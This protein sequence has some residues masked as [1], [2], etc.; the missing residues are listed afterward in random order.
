M[1]VDLSLGF[2]FCSIDLLQHHSSKASI[3]WHSAIFTVQLSHPYMTTG[4]TTALTRRTFVGKAMS[5]LFNMLSRLV[6]SFLPRSKH[7][8]IS[9]LQSQLQW[10]WSPRK[11]VSHCSHCFHIYLPWSDGTG[12]HDLRF[13]WMLNFKPAFYSPLSLSRGSLVS[14]SPIG[15]C[16]LHIWGYWY[17]SCQSWFQLVLHPAQHFAWIDGAYQ[18]FTGD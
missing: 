14:L 11:E 12:C 4:E 7:L 2:L 8:L 16:H 5:L 15:W 3:I 13:F 10:F 6:I 18:K 1:C 9:W 17:F